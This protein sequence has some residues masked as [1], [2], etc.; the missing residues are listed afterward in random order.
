MR[1]VTICDRDSKKVENLRSSLHENIELINY[2]QSLGYFSK[3]FNFYNYLLSLKVSDKE[4]IVFVDGYDV[5][6]IK[7]KLEDLEK[8][9]ILTGKDVICSAEL[10][11]AHHR[12][13]VTK[14]FERK[15][16]GKTLKFLNSGFWIGYYG[17]LL[18]MFSNIVENFKSYEKGIKKHD[19]AIIS[20]F[21]MLN[22]RELHL[23]NMDVDYD[24]VF[25]FTFCTKHFIG[26]VDLKKLKSYFVHVTWLDNPMQND[27]YKKV[28]EYFKLVRERNADATRKETK[29]C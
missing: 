17:S 21:M 28:V 7:F 19:Q 18:K 15:Y 25:C 11:S 12:S 1:I 9:F 10:I 6:C 13:D 20:Y 29:A 14:L 16:Y 24:A 26:D 3:I 8:D 5:I 23:V 27:K 22:E 4:V 2:D